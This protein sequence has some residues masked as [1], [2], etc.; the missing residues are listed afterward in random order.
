MSDVT[1]RRTLKDGRIIYEIE[2]GLDLVKHLPSFK[3]P[4]FSIREEEAS[5]GAYDPRTVK[6]AIRSLGCGTWDALSW[7]VV[8]ERGNLVLEGKSLK[9]PGGGMMPPD[10]L[11]GETAMPIVGKTPSAADNELAQALSAL[12]PDSCTLSEDLQRV[13]ELAANIP[14]G[15][16]VSVLAF[17]GGWWLKGSR[18]PDRVFLVL[19]ALKRKI[20]ET[21]QQR[22]G[23]YVRGDEFQDFL[24]DALRRMADQPDDK[25]RKIL[26]NIILG[27]VDGRHRDHAENRLFLR[28][29]DEL[30]T[31][32]LFLLP[33]FEGSVKSGEADLDLE[34]R[35][36]G[37]TGF[38]RSDI[39]EIL[40]ELERFGVIDLERKPA[41]RAAPSLNDNGPPQTAEGPGIGRSY[42]YFLT[43][44]GRGFDSFRRG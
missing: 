39:L 30:S 23:A 7:E 27:I 25:R 41:P 26:E 44:V 36:A 6:A 35:L 15:S 29:A 11:T 10:N 5:A 40:R 2:E 28:L 38:P 24:E 9:S 1:V 3:G 17:L 13:L 14:G 16:I 12:L 19:L 43:S 31:R 22:H 42:D 18:K 33:A 4:V 37:R 34:D 8:D 21:E 20:D 32:A